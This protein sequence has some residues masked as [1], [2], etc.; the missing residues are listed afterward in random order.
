MKAVELAVAQEDGW[1]K[2]AITLI[3][4]LRGALESNRL[5]TAV[6]SVQREPSD[7]NEASSV[8]SAGTLTI[9]A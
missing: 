3:M 1:R 6:K 8:P 4:A 7:L 2:I 5:I 9:L